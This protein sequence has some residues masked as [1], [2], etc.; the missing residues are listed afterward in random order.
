MIIRSA[1]I[2]APDISK[3]DIR[4]PISAPKTPTGGDGVTLLADTV[5]DELAK[6]T[7]PATVTPGQ[8]SVQLSE[9]RGTDQVLNPGEAVRLGKFTVALD[10]ASRSVVVEETTSERRAELGE[11]GI[12]TPKTSIAIMRLLARDGSMLYVTMVPIIS[13]AE[14]GQETEEAASDQAAEENDGAADITTGNEDVK[15]D[16]E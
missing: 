13:D 14:L 11:Q 7:P 15:N 10:Q 6:P 3:P 5:Q 8:M 2:Q 4:T 12:A 1:N 9:P 16:M